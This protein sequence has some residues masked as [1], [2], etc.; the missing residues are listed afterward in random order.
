LIALSAAMYVASLILNATFWPALAPTGDSNDKAILGAVGVVIE[1]ANYTIPTAISLVSLSGRPKIF[2]WAFWTATI[3]AAAIAGA[4]FVRGNFGAAEVSRQTTINERTRL[5]GII[6]A[7]MTPASDATVVDARKRIDTAKADRKATCAPI[8]SKDV[9]ECNKSRAAVTKAE[10]DL[11]QAN[12]THEANVKAAE[13]QHRKD[14]ADAQAALKALPAT[15]ND[16]NV[17]LAGVAAIIPGASEAWVNGIVAGLWV[18]LFSFAPCM[19]LR[20][21]LALL[22]P[23]PTATV[24]DDAD[25]AAP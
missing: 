17:V 19:L 8:R 23:T 6:N 20:L 11:K 2:L 13:Q 21:G 9:D 25:G 24:R 5:Q 14:V 10:A 4:G 15:S 7:P 18:A 22:A 16:K 3:I 12:E 1:T